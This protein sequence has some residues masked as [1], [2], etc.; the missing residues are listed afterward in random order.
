MLS[1]PED[2]ST[3]PAFCTPGVCRYEDI[4]HDLYKMQPGTLRHCIIL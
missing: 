4:L 1:A 2:F 3:S